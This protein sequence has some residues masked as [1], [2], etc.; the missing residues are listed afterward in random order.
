MACSAYVDLNPVRAGVAAT[1]EESQYTSAY[2]RIAAEQAERG[3]ESKAAR[4]VGLLSRTRC[5]AALK[6]QRERDKARSDGWLAPVPLDERASAYRGAMP[7]ANGQRASDKGFLAMSLEAYLQLLDWT[8]RQMRRDHKRGRIPDSVAPILQRLGISGNTWCDMVKRYCT[9][10]Q[11]VAGTP[12]SLSR[13]AA[14]RNEGWH[15]THSSPLASPT[16]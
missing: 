14:S 2:E 6:A 8:G 4:R 1:P 5:K 12:D 10:F 13:E 11:R 7:S 3:V 16:G 15:Q 9:I